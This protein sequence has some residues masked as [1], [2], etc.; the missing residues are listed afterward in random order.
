[1]TQQKKYCV[2]CFVVMQWE[3]AYCPRCTYPQPLEYNPSYLQPPYKLY[4]QYVIG[5]VL[6]HGAFGVTYLAYDR[7]LG[8]KAAIKEYF[9]AELSSRD[10]QSL[11]VIPHAGSKGE[12]FVKG[13]KKFIAEARLLSSFRSPHIIRLRHFFEASNTAYFVMEYLEGQ[14]LRDYLKGRGGKMSFEDIYPLLLALLDALEEVH[15]HDSLH[16]DIKPDNIYMALHDHPILLDFGSARLLSSSKQ[17]TTMSLLTPGFAPIEQYSQHG[18]QGA[19]TDIYG[20]AATIYFLLTAEHPTTPQDR[21]TGDAELVPASQKGGNLRPQD[22]AWLMKGLEL[23][24][25]DRPSSIQEWRKSLPEPP[26]HDQPQQ[27]GEFSS[28]DENFMRFA[29]MPKL[30]SRFL[31]PEDEAEIFESAEFLNISK[32]HTQRLLKR[33]LDITGSVKRN[34]EKERKKA[35]K[36]RLELE[37]KIQQEQQ[38]SATEQEVSSVP[39]SLTFSEVFQPQKLV[40]ADKNLPPTLLNSLQMRFQLIIPFNQSGS[41]RVPQLFIMGKGKNKAS[42]KLSK[43]YYLQTSPVTQSQW[44]KVM[45]ENPS[46]FTGHDDLPVEQVSWQDCQN[47]L[48]RLNLLR[49]GN[50]RLPTEAEWAFACQGGQG[51]AYFF[52]KDPNLLKKYAWHKENTYQTQA[53]EQ[54]QDNPYGLYDLYG[55]VWEWTSDYYAP[56]PKGQSTDPQ[57]PEKTDTHVV[58]GGCWQSNAQECNSHSRWHEK[59]GTRSFLIGFRVLLEVDEDV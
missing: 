1:M 44:Q 19:W 18:V 8:V 47:F 27:I 43:R 10:P 24:W 32:D 25:N 16:R 20:L 23:R 31:T 5:R 54:L 12:L 29:I 33:A 59:P 38:K 46:F 34:P 51:T 15:S 40:H 36:Q 58:R 14:T 4:H 42:V 45:G 6:G 3:Q 28:A 35:E 26:R 30:V 13:K 49:E 37:A 53:V 39:H 48:K 2:N 7:S 17:A 41:L 9:P 21:L 56:I 57:G 52:G 22:E 55:N 50:Y 11:K